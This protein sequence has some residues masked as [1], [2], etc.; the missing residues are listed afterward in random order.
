MAFQIHGA[1]IDSLL[2][3]NDEHTREID[4]DTFL[5]THE[6]GGEE[7]Q[8]QNEINESISDSFNASDVMTSTPLKDVRWGGRDEADTTAESSGKGIGIEVE[9]EEEEEEER[10]R[11]KYYAETKAEEADDEVEEKEEGKKKRKRKRKNVRFK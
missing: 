2:S 7:G 3:L 4:I 9:E 10:K 5:L 8:A 11:K 1:V 6:D